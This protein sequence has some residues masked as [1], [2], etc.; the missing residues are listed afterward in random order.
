MIRS[1]RELTHVERYLAEHA[2]GT[3]RFCGLNV[4]KR[5]SSRR[6]EM[7][8]F[9]R[10]GVRVV[11]DGNGEVHAPGRPCCRETLDRLLPADAGV[12]EGSLRPF[13][14]QAA[15]VVPTVGSDRRAGFQARLH[16]DP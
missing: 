5:R 16:A 3:R 15:T 10:C 2:G 8:P 7:V 1:S 6:S 4:M 13:H 12:G 9:R 14:L 11:G